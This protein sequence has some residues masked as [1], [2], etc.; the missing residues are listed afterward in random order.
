MCIRDRL[1]PDGASIG[2]AEIPS[3]IWEEDA[4][5][6]K[7]EVYRG[8]TE[9]RLPVT[10]ADNQSEALIKVGYQGCA[11]IGICYPPIFKEIKL[12]SFTPVAAVASASSTG[13]AGSALV[14]VSSATA[15]TTASNKTIQPQ[16]EQDRL[17]DSL[18]GGNRW[19]T[20]ATFFGLSL[21]HISEPTRPY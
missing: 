14:A 9:I 20:I 19:V 13:S 16:A 12:A 11:D 1:S 18:K 7:S 5:F 15:A 6:G 10:L 4:F 17:A 21:I 8:S 2:E 3:G